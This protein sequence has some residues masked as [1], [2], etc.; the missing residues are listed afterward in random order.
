LFGSHI[1][2]RAA[3]D[4]PVQ[5]RALASP[6]DVRETGPPVGKLL[7]VRDDGLQLIVASPGAGRVRTVAWDVDDDNE[8]A[9]VPLEA[10]AAVFGTRA[11]TLVTQVVQASGLTSLRVLSMPLFGAARGGTLLPAGDTVRGLA[12]T[13]GHVDVL[14]ASEGG[15]R[16]ARWDTGRDAWSDTARWPG[17]MVATV[18]GDGRSVAVAIGR[19]VV[20]TRL[21]GSASARS[22]EAAA[23]PTLLAL[24]ADGR[25]VA[26]FA[27]GAVQVWA[28][29]GGGPWAHT[30]PGRATAGAVSA[31]GVYGIAVTTDDIATRG[32]TLHT[33]WR[34]RLAG[35]ADAIAVDLGRSLR[36][37][38]TA[39]MVSNDGRSLRS[40]GALWPLAAAS[41]P[42][43]A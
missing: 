14:L 7:A 5:I 41:A 29:G 25:H 3:F 32:G 17:A 4:S 16:L 23:P 2:V 27:G 42:H 30:L 18:S 33:L 8:R 22:F 31:D 35:P 34:W 40:G 28:T 24:G 43:R 15:L 21:D 37:I 9:T 6:A 38:D 13:D 36:P 20:V 39:C 26:A 12:V 10:S 1:A 19:S 11:A